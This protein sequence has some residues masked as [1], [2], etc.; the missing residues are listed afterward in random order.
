VRVPTRLRRRYIENR[1]GKSTITL[2]VRSST[3]IRRCRY[4]RTYFC[5]RFGPRSSAMQLPLEAL[6][7]VQS[8]IREGAELHDAYAGIARGANASVECP[9]TS[10]YHYP[11]LDFP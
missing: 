4:E 6:T 7:A 11:R 3:A 2:T 9:K 8:L 1:V 5:R 10:V